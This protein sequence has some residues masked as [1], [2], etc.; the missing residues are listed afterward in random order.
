MIDMTMLP[1]TLPAA[2]VKGVVLP[3]E[4][5][6]GTD[7]AVPDAAPAAKATEVAGVA[8]AAAGA[9][10]PAARLVAEGPL[11][12]YTWGTVTAVLTTD[13]VVQA[14]G[15]IEVGA[16]IWPS[17]IWLTAPLADGQGRVSV[18]EIEMVVTGPAGAAVGAT[19][20][21]PAGAD[22]ACCGEFATLAG[23]DTGA[24]VTGAAGALDVAGGVGSRVIVDG[25]LVTMPGF[26]DT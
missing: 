2:P 13:V 25:T 6:T 23:E 24:E 20:T 3:V 14:P 18:V 19:V 7:D 16:W 22:E 12:M 17:V 21:E 26:A 15:A 1:S 8:L 5:G 9:G 10:I 11:E 4:V